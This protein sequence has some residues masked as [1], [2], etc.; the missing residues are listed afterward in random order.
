MLLNTKQTKN[1]TIKKIPSQSKAELVAIVAFVMWFIVSNALNVHDYISRSALWIIPSCYLLY[2]FWNSEGI[3]SCVLSKSFLWKIGD[4]SFEAF[5]LH[6]PVLCLLSF[7]LPLYEWNTQK[8]VV[9]I[10]Y[11]FLIT[12]LFSSLCCARTKQ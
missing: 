5:L 8:C 2:I 4:I 11:S 1:I 10:L 12:C 3:C 9:V 7:L 6:Y